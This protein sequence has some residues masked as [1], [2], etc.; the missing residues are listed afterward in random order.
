MA[1][2]VVP[3]DP[4]GDLVDGHVLTEVAAVV[5]VDDDA[6]GSAFRIPMASLRS[7]VSHSPFQMSLQI[8]R[9]F[10]ERRCDTRLSSRCRHGSPRRSLGRCLSVLP[11]WRLLS[12]D[13]H[14]GDEVV[15]LVLGG[16]CVPLVEP[17]VPQQRLGPVQQE[18]GDGHGVQPVDRDL[19][20]AAGAVLVQRGRGT[21]PGRWGS[22]R[23]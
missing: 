7:S 2:F 14:D 5:A 15:D 18:G 17:D 20:G 9:A 3:A 21:R 1:A 13:V 6:S 22:P 12:G 4:G 16:V 23:I 11:C 8:V 10:H 19:H